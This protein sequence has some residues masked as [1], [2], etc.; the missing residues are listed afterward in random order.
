MSNPFAVGIASLLLSWNR[1][2]GN[3]IKLNCSE[4]YRAIFK[5]HTFSVKDKNFAKNK[6]FEGFGIIDPKDL[7]S[8]LSE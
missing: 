5:K 2:N 4:D 3:K 1:S 6:F 7:E 8:W